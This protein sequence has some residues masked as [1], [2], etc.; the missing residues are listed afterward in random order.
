VQLTFVRTTNQTCGTEVWFP[1]LNIRRRLPLNEPVN[2][3]LGS[4]AR[5]SV[6]FQCGMNMLRGTILVR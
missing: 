2:I 5:G 1:A 3:E 4:V 6:A